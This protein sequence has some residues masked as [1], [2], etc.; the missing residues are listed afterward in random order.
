MENLF[1]QFN[2]IEAQ[3]EFSSQDLN[4]D[5]KF[6]FSVPQILRDIYFIVNFMMLEITVLVTAVSALLVHLISARIP[7]V[8]F[9]FAVTLPFVSTVK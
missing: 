4:K 9:A 7:S 3:K 8:A 5:G 1:T 6:I 2:D